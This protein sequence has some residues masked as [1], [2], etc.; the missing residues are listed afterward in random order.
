MI[1]LLLGAIGF[2]FGLLLIE[3]GKRKSAEA[4]NE[5]LETKKEIQEMQAQ[6]DLNDAQLQVEEQKRKELEEQR[7]NLSKKVDSEEL[8]KFFNDR[9]SSK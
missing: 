2:V 7:K 9:D 6:I 8:S 1:E 4:L 5:N 3:V